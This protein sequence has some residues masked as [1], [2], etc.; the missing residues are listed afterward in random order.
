MPSTPTIRDI[1]RAAGVHH[2]TVSRVL[3]NHPRISETTRQ[4]VQDAVQRLGYRPNPLVSALM[5][6]R[7]ER[8][9]AAPDTGLALLLYKR[10]VVATSIHSRH[11]G[12]AIRQRAAE[13]GFFVE[14]YHADEFQGRPEHLV[15]AWR[16]RGIVGVLIDA[17]G[18]SQLPT[19]LELSDFACVSIGT[20]IR[21][22]PT[23]QSDH[24]AGMLCAW[25]EIIRLGYR[26][27]GFYLHSHIENLTEGRWTAAFLLMQQTLPSADRLPVFI[28]GSA[29]ERRRWAESHAPDVIINNSVRQ[30]L[31]RFDTVALDAIRPE[32]SGIDQRRSAIAATAVDLI[33]AQLSRN[34]RGRAEAPLR[35]LVPGR[36]VEGSTCRG[37]SAVQ[38]GQ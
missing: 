1:A 9:T 6:Q 16:A 32:D 10:D 3:N 24:F 8:R 18:E 33:A 35:T 19:G 21:G 28:G 11:D 38:A 34:E 15:R 14:A 22:L 5:Q 25:R 2:A 26:R 13:R 20:S 23:V 30:E 37:A 27:P 31:A 17:V 12:Q 29:R 4:R 7:T 36:W